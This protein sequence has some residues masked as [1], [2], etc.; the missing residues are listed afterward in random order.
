MLGL[1]RLRFPGLKTFNYFSISF[2]RR[3]IAGD[4]KF[5]QNEKI[6]TLFIC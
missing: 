4:F 3:Y 2:C 1:K 5:K 6:N